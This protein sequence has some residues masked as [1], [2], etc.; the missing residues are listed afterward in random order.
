MWIRSTS[1]A[2]LI[3]LRHIETIEVVC[4]MKTEH[5]E[6]YAVLASSHDNSWYLFSGSKAECTEALD[7]L[8]SLLKAE[9]L[10]HDH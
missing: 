2:L 4:K 10:R 8:E 1:R 3:S 7:G 6:M 5:D 9:E